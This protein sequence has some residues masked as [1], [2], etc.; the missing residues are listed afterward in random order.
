[1]IASTR[2]LVC[3]VLLCGRCFA[4]DDFF[5]ITSWEQPYE[6]QQQ[7]GDPRMG[8][9]GLGDC[10]F[11]VAGFVTAD[12]VPL[13]EKAKMRALVALP[14]PFVKWKE[15]S[16]EQIAAT[17]SK[18]VA[19]TEKSDAVIGYFLADEP[20]ASDFSALAKAVAAVKKHAPG[21]LAYINLF[22]DYGTLGAPGLSQLET[23]TYSDY[24]ERYVAEVKPQFISYDN[25]I[26]QYSQDQRD[27]AA[28]AGYYRN[29]LGVRRVALKHDLPFWN[30]VASNQQK[31]EMPIPSPAN[32]SLQAYTT[33]AAGG[34]G[35]TW[36]TY[37]AGGY[38]YAAV[39]KAGNRTATW[40]Y[41]KMVNEQVK[42]LGPVMNR[43]KST[44][45]YFTAPL[46]DP[47]LPALPGKVIETATSSTPVMV[48][49]FA[50]AD[51]T[52]HVML[53]NLSLERSSLIRLKTRKPYQGILAAS[54]ADGSFAPLAEK[55][56]IWLPAGQGALLR[57][58]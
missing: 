15:L 47:S 56:S 35:L 17:V 50:A 2:T 44:G 11:T 57:F 51:G 36:Y 4:G 32:L 34:R 23:Q 13:C 54:P 31:P 16:D 24:L 43:L 7:M 14:G 26:V 30:I 1:M 46:P 53:V 9:A 58:E 39:D 38:H 45:V 41:L 27:P 49:E 8:P 3:L 25:Y 12:Q 6:K 48:G 33:L 18:L 42:V 22:P 29:L 20:G 21:K 10:G 52:P 28:A 55:D 37:Y 40:C 5:P 19:G